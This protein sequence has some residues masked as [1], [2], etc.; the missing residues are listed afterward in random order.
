MTYD[1]QKNFIYKGDNYT[2]GLWLCDANGWMV[3]L[4]GGFGNVPLKHAKGGIAD[5]CRKL[6][7]QYENEDMMSQMMGA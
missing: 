7:A 1:I 5:I 2:V 3:D 6:V 4:Q